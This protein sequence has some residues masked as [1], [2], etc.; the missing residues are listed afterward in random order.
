MQGR[1]P[2]NINVSIP[3]IDAESLVI[4]LDR[5]DIFISTGAACSAG[6]SQ[7]SHVLKA[8]GY[9]NDRVRGAIRISV[10]ESNTIGE[11]EKVAS[12]ITDEVFR[13]YEAS[14]TGYY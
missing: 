9:N 11:I 14:G 4:R 8:L 6:A 1:L 3:G 7:P 12:V 5:Q 13:M 10:S 2:G